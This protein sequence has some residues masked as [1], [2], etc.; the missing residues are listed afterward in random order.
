[1]DPPDHT[2]LRRLVA[3]EFT[4]RRVAQLRER[5]RTL[6]DRLLDDMVRT[7]PPADIMHDFALPT[8]I[9]TICELLGVPIDDREKFV[10]WAGGALSTELDRIEESMRSLLGYLGELAERRVSEPTDDLIGALVRARDEQGSLTA[11]ELVKLAFV[12]LIGGFET[13]AN[14]I[15]NAVYAL[16]TRPDQLALLRADP[17]LAPQAVEECLRYLPISTGTGI[18]RVA[19]ADVELGGVLIR[20]G[21]TVFMDEPCANRDESVF[22][23]AD[24]FDVTRSHN[25]HLAFGH[26]VHHC[27]GAPLARMEMQVAIGC[28]LARFP[29]LRLAVDADEVPWQEGQ[30]T[31]APLTLPVAW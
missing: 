12:L 24:V 13:V 28:L 15:S 22:D 21:D 5:T 7:G 16:L 14:S 9:T 8:S 11:D 20:A 10:A 3:G 17:E 25:P 6:V 2:R 23:N 1:M 31:R 4:V 19:L 27:I 18:P 26:G 29:N 30:L